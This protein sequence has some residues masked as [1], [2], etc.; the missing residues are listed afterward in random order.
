MERLIELKR[1]VDDIEADLN[2][3]YPHFKSDKNISDK[4]TAL[5][6][7]ALA[8]KTEIQGQLK[9][10]E[11]TEFERHFIEPAIYD[12]YM[13]GIDKIRK[14]AKPSINLTHLIGETEST[15]S[16]WVCEIEEY[17]KKEM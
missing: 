16:Y 10:D 6:E 12:A 7:Y 3:M 9:R 5:K 11:L 13:K 1:R 14:G 4:V 17:Q 2:A 15:I 8:I